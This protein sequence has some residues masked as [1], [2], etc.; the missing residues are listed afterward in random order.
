MGNRQTRQTFTQYFLTIIEIVTNCS[1]NLQQISENTTADKQQEL[2]RDLKKNC[3]ISVFIVWVI[4]CIF[5]INCARALSVR[6]LSRRISRNFKICRKNEWVKYLKDNRERKWLE[7]YSFLMRY[8]E[9]V[10]YLWCSR[11]VY[12]CSPRAYSKV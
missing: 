5:F 11:T 9:A 10:W 3:N 1:W 2:C 12:I 4:N 8:I 7:S 6:L